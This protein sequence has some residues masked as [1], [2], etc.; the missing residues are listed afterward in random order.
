MEKVIINVCK[1]HERF[2]GKKGEEIRKCWECR[3]DK[4]IT[5]L[6]EQ[7]RYKDMYGEN[8]RIVY[9]AEKAEG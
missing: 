8:W 3:R 9:D 1:Q 6:I 4:T 2:L 5:E 7:D